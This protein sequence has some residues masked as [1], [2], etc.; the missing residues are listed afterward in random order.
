VAAVSIT[1]KAT[2]GLGSYI[3]FLNCVSAITNL[4]LTD[5]AAVRKYFRV[6]SMWAC[7]RLHSGVNL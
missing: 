3:F 5:S 6:T 7:I 4:L 2:G 1:G